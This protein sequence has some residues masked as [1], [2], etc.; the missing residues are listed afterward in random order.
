M[1]AERLPSSS[2]PHSDAQFPQDSLID[3]ALPAA[4]GEPSIHDNRWRAGHAVRTGLGHSGLTGEIVHL[5]VA[6]LAGQ[7]L[8]PAAAAPGHHPELS[9]DGIQ[10]FWE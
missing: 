3:G 1:V 7:L 9:Y 2:D 6:A 8:V 10:I 4:V 5:H